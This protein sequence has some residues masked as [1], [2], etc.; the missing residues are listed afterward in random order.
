MALPLPTF[1]ATG[2]SFGGRVLYEYTCN[3]GLLVYIKSSSPPYAVL[4]VMWLWGELPFSKYIPPHPGQQLLGVMA[5]A[6]V[7]CFL[8]YVPLGVGFP[9][10]FHG[11][12]I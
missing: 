11:S 8:G 4:P 7:P 6:V 2:L 10:L 9:I 3:T 1:A 12:S 5:P